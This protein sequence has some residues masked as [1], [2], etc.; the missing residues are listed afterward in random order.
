MAY[1]LQPMKKTLWQKFLEN[2]K[3]YI[4]K[5]IPD[6]ITLFLFLLVIN[7]IYFEFIEGVKEVGIGNTIWNLIIG[8]FV[9]FFIVIVA[10][11]MGEEAGGALAFLIILFSLFFGT[12]LTS[13][14]RP[15]IDKG[16][17]HDPRVNTEIAYL[18]S[19]WKTNGIRYYKNDF[20]KEKVF[21]K[22]DSSKS[23]V[24]SVSLEYDFTKSGIPLEKMKDI[25]V[26]MN[27]LPDSKDALDMK[28][29]FVA[30]MNKIP[31]RFDTKKWVKLFSTE[32]YK[33]SFQISLN[34]KAKEVGI[35]ITK[36]NLDIT[37]KENN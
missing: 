20:A 31:S 32:E 17:I 21:S 3:K 27:A 5:I 37:I 6:L 11:L 36:V 33:N 25:E 24:L 26:A 35:S 34:E 1:T 10:M 23:I 4:M 19:I 7:T 13:P 8:F 2:P 9:I 18:D 30:H 16:E 28:A 29:A 14:E 15:F 12:I 22:M